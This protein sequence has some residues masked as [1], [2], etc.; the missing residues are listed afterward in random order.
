MQTLNKCVKLIKLNKGLN[1][2]ILHVPFII[3]VPFMEFK[4]RIAKLD[5]MP[6][7]ERLMYQSITKLLGYY[8]DEEE[9]EA[10]FE[11]MGLD[12]QLIKDKSYFLIF[13]GEILVGCGGWSN[14]KTL[15]GGNHTPN[16]SDDFLD[17]NN[18]AAKIRA[19]YTNPNWARKGVGTLILKLAE[20]EASN[21]GFKKCELMATLSGMHLYKERGYK[22]DE[23]TIYESKKGNTVKMFKMT[24][25][26][27]LTNT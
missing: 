20:K 23:E 14:R 5:D 1:I 13:H 12:D 19:M 18:D 22:I 15:F 10:S 25:L 16:R 26:L 8:V 4:H 7:I 9:L 24:K 2:S 17:P 27:N 6:S 3:Y 11:S 21:F